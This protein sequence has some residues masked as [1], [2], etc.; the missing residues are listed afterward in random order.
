MRARL[1]H[2]DEARRLGERE[3]HLGGGA[4]EL[5]AADGGGELVRQVLLAHQTE[6][7]ATRIG[8]RH[9]DRRA[10]LFTIVQHCAGGAAP[11][12]QNL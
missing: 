9:H 1:R 6:E 7:R 12:N 10:Q 5:V 2:A 4:A 3:I 11:R 8:T